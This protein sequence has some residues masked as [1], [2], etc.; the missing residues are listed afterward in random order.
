MKR[1][2]SVL[3]ILCLLM[4]ILPLTALAASRQYVEVTKA[5]APLRSGNTEKHSVVVRA[6][7]G[8]V[9]EVLDTSYNTYLNKWYKVKTASGSAYIYSG[10]VKKVNPSGY[11]TAITLTKSSVALNLA[12]TRTASLKAVCRYKSR[13][14][15]NV[16]WYTSHPKVATVDSK[17]NVTAKGPGTCSITARHNIY[18]TLAY[19]TVTVTEQRTL[20]TLSR[21]QSNNKCCSGAVA[22][23]VLKY[24][25]GSSFNKTDLQLFKEMGNSGAVYKVVNI[26][27]KYMG[28]TAYM[29]TR[30]RTQSAYEQAVF[31]SIRAGYPVIALVK[32]TGSSYFKYTSNGHFT[33][34]SGYRINPNGTVDFR[35]TDSFKTGKNG[36]YFWIPSAT[37]FSYSKAHGYPYYLIL[38]K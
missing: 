18:G 29:Y 2:T 34:V 35:I 17:G 8:T 30:A 4:T 32:I 10:N 27:N 21:E 26:L 38:K 7:K 3:L 16:T 1:L 24:L 6:T 23:S 20:G 25:R 14:D 31:V 37:F 12:G 22:W 19:C 36:G 15:A 9:L 5:D 13:I 11:T 33:I 28:R